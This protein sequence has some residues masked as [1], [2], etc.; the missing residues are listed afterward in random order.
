MI[1]ADEKAILETFEARAMDAVALENN[2]GLVIAVHAIGLQDLIG[3]GQGAV[4]SG[5]A[6][7]QH[8]V[9]LLAHGAQ[10]LAAGEGRSDRIAIGTS[11]RRQHE[12]IA[13]LDLLKHIPQKIHGDVSLFLACLELLLAGIGL[14]FRSLP[15]A[16][17]QLF[18]A[19]FLAL[20]PVEAKEQFWRAAQAQARSQF[21]ADVFARSLETLEASVGFI[22]I[23]VDVDQDLR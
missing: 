6:V 21:V 20:G 7:V 5:N 11:V 17:Q 9:G 4:D 15:G 14:R 2:R 8:D 19:G 22:I 10:D 3:E 16:G 23:A 18:Y 1:D 12:A 13:L